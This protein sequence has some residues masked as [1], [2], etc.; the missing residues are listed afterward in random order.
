M[1]PASKKA[2]G[3]GACR[4]ARVGWIGGFAELIVYDLV[5]LGPFCL[6][7]MLTADARFTVDA[8][9]S[10]PLRTT[11]AFLKE[12]ASKYFAPVALS[13]L[14]AAPWLAS[15]LVH[16]STSNRAHGMPLVEDA[17]PLTPSYAIHMFLP[18]LLIPYGGNIPFLK[19]AD[20]VDLYIGTMTFLI[21]LTLPFVWRS[22]RN[23]TRT[24]FL[25]L[26]AFGLI[27]ASNTPLYDF[28]HAFPVLNWF[29][30]HFKWTFLTAFAAG[31][32]VGYAA[33]LLPA[34]R[35]HRYARAF[36]KSLW[37]CFGLGALGELAFTIRRP[38]RTAHLSTAPR[39]TA[40]AA[41][42]PPRAC[43]PGLLRLDHDMMSRAS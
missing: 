42:N 26:L 11:L 2:A 43:S 8:W 20:D 15:V 16:I 31:M 38:D 3:R 9:R 17:L 32:L 1:P 27:M 5:A 36:V 29:R 22:A 12:G 7:L 41:P 40:V 24:F 21:L 33:D 28:F 37:A 13:T 39:T 6:F 19:L 4:D 35:E 14:I 30:W 18:R 25:G 23:T 10:A 34:F